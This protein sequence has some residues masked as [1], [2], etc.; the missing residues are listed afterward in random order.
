MYFSQA[1]RTELYRKF[2]PYWNQWWQDDNQN[3]A[4]IKEYWGTFKQTPASNNNGVRV[5]LTLTNPLLESRKA[6]NVDR[7][8]WQGHL[9]EKCVPSR[10]HTHVTRHMLWKLPQ[11]HLLTPHFRGSCSPLET[12]Q[13]CL[14][15]K[16]LGKQPRVPLLRFHPQSLS[17]TMFTK[18]CFHP[19]G[20]DS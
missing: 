11:K 18:V 15:L 16:L 13:H 6:F 20:S 3:A 4:Q 5:P 7:F 1:K 12:K 9:A 14:W 19:N 2:H 17:P 8:W 10:Q